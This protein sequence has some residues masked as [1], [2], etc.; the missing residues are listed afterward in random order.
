MKNYFVK[1]NDNSRYE[2]MFSQEELIRELKSGKLRP[3]WL[4]AENPEGVSY[5]EFLKMGEG[6]WNSLFH[7]SAASSTPE[8]SQTPPSVPPLQPT[9]PQHQQAGGFDFRKLCRIIAWSG[10]AVACYGVF[11]A[12]QN[13]PLSELPQTQESGR[14]TA[15]FFNRVTRDIDNSG[16]VLANQIRDRKRTDAY[17][18]IAVGGVIVF[19]ALAL[20]SCVKRT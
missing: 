19:G 10:I 4:V 2:G 16:V 12:S 20:G 14:A 6:Q 5:N 3:E 18:I 1:R 15:D 8:E 13:R 11:R 7:F 17:K 9:P